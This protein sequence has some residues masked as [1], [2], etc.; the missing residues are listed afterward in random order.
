LCLFN[1]PC[2][3]NSAACGDRFM[4]NS[5][6]FSTVPVELKHEAATYDASLLLEVRVN[7]I[8]VYHMY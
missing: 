2:S 4:L 7:V 1:C 3:L 6:V 5:C 8:N